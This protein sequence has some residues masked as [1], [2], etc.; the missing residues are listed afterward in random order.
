M[1]H[2]STTLHGKMS[3]E[4]CLS[5]HTACMLYF[6]GIS[7]PN[8]VQWLPE[9]DWYDNR[10][11]E[12]EHEGPSF[13]PVAFYC[14]S[15]WSCLGSNGS[16]LFRVHSRGTWRSLPS[17]EWLHPELWIAK[18]YVLWQSSCISGHMFQCQVSGCEF[19]KNGFSSFGHTSQKLHVPCSW[20]TL[21]SSASFHYPYRP[22]TQLETPA[23]S[24]THPPTSLAI[25]KG[26]YTGNL[27]SVMGS[28]SSVFRT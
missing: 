3:P 9:Q 22:Q 23:S 26:K 27:A 20:V 17:R 7:L 12:S 11:R 15:T 18:C 8:H 6:Y 2:M 28:N 13:Y 4:I 24:S 1:P 16:V 14:A 5:C 19:C 10:G 25:Q 21:C